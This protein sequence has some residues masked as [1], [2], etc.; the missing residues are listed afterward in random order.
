MNEIVMAP[1]RTKP[2]QRLAVITGSTRGL[3][4]GIAAALLGKSYDVMVCARDGAEASSAAQ[5]LRR[6]AVGRVDGAACDVCDPA[7]I[8]A[9]WSTTQS[10]LGTP[11]VWINN[12][13]IALTG[14]TLDQT[15]YDEL[16]AMTEVNLLGTMAGCRVAAAHMQENGGA[17][18]NIYGAGSDG[19]PVPG[20][21]GYGTT[22]RAVQFFT[23]A[24][25]RELDPTR[26]IVCGLSPG[27]VMTEGFFREHANVADADRQTREAVIDI[28]GDHV[29]SVAGWIADIIESNQRSG[30]DF[31]WLNEEKIAQRRA[32]GQSRGILAQYRDTNGALPKMRL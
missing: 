20:M 10:R 23:Q 28:L 1:T 9:L 11:S 26:V 3:G 29:S 32:A 31:T 7:Q 17:I 8:E 25:A 16:R 12:A 24:L 18:Y 15:G 5:S 27:L 19:Q 6:D 4:Y 21:I 22:K 14:R 2:A 13:G 30:V